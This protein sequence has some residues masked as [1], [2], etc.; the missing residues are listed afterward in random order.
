M[1]AVSWPFVAVRGGLVVACLVNSMGSIASAQTPSTGDPTDARIASAMAGYYRF[2]SSRSVDDLR[3]TAINLVSVIDQRALRTGDVTGHRRSVVAAFAKVLSGL[4]AISD[5]GFD[6]SQRPSACVTPPR[7]PSGRQALH[8]A[9][10]EDVLDPAARAQYQAAIDENS[11]KIIHFSE[12]MRISHATAD[13]MGMLELV[14]HRFHRRAP[15]DSAALDDIL[16]KAGL[17]KDR[18]AK[19]HAMY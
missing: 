19:I 11:M 14:L 3:N 13:T 9:A 15:D 4:E 16:Q 8:C 5:P 2:Q 18:R 6:P 1:A 12:Q 7:E 17:S 10:P